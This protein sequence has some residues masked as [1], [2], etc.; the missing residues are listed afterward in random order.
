MDLK[1]TGEKN[2]KIWINLI[3]GAL[4]AG[5]TACGG[6][7]NDG[8][9][10]SAMTLTVKP[11]GDKTMAAN[12][13]INLTISS[14]VRRASSTD[15]NSVSSMTWT[16]TGNGGETVN[17]VLSNGTCAASNNT[18][19]FAECSTVLSVPQSVTTGQW[20]LTASARA[21][22]GTQ[23]SESM[24]INVNNSVYNLHAGDAQNFIGDENGVFEVALLKGTLSGTNG[25]K[26]VKVLWTQVS[27][28]TVE[29]ANPGSMNASFTPLVNT[30]AEYKFQLS[31][32]VDD[33]TI[34]STTT[35]TTNLKPVAP[36]A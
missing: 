29:I 28:P 26:I 36:A 1:T 5:L 32:T 31:V 27:G 20:T 4:V 9:D 35:V 3:N 18:G 16:L 33:Q 10:N 34:N 11:S 15:T 2:E 23:R 12:S 8:V 24:L 14:S 30:A 21:S 13:T 19:I 25:G 17:P 22:N 7:G 6:G